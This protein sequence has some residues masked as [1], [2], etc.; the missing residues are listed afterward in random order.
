MANHELGILEKNK[1]DLIVEVC[2]EIIMGKLDDH[3]PLVI[4]QRLALVPKPI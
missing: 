4:W 2:D 3:F 1:K